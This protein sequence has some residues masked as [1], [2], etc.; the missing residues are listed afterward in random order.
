MHS[1]A[2]FLSMPNEDGIIM[3]GKTA[4]GFNENTMRGYPLWLPLTTLQ[5]TDIV[6][7]QKV[8]DMCPTIVK[9]FWI[10]KKIG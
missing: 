10:L 1:T 7:A 6:S 9:R 5:V 4:R 2:A 8:E 3:G